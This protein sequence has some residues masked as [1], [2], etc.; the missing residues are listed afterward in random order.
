M[1]DPRTHA[2]GAVG[3]DPPAA[4]VASAPPGLVLR[5]ARGAVPVH[6]TAADRAEATVGIQERLATFTLAR[7]FLRLVAGAVLGLAPELVPVGRED[8]GKPILR[9]TDQHVSVSHT[10]TDDSGIVGVVLAPIAVGLDIEPV[11]VRR[12]GLADR[13]LAP[14]ESLPDWTPDDAS[15][16]IATWTAK[17]AALKADGIGLWQGAKAARLVW[18]EGGSFT[19]ETPAGHWQGRTIIEEGLAWS[20]AWAASSF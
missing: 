1:D 10:A 3:E 7:S 14:G 17:E 15:A 19:A 12:A 18:G 9:G 5:I 16:V 6:L 2:A 8:R 4:L 11:R 20:L 13:I